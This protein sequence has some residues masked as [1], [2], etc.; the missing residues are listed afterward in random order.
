M[1]RVGDRF[2][3]RVEQSLAGNDVNGDSIAAHAG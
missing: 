3:L 1:E 2:P